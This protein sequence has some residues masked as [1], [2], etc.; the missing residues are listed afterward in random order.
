MV[1]ALL[2]RRTVSCVMPLLSE[3]LR[4]IAWLARGSGAPGNLASGAAHREPRWPRA[5]CA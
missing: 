1:G 5:S 4:E 2:R 3:N